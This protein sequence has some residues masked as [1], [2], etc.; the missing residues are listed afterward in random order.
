MNLQEKQ[1][2]ASE[3]KNQIREKQAQIDDLLKI[4]ES[5]LYSIENGVQS[6]KIELFSELLKK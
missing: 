6:L 3:L 5:K 1:Q 4:V 2:K